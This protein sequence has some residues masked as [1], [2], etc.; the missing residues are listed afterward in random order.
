MMLIKYDNDDKYNKSKNN[1]NNILVEDIVN[2][3][4]NN[5]IVFKFKNVNVY[6]DCDSNNIVDILSKYG[7]DILVCSI[8]E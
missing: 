7:S 2:Q 8:I 5:N 6:D 1:P 4:I 3:I